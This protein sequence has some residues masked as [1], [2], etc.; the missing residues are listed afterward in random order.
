MSRIRGYT[1][2]AA[3]LAARGIGASEVA[4]IRGR[5]TFRTAW[6]VWVARQPDPPG[7]E[8]IQQT[9]RQAEGHELEPEILAAYNAAESRRTGIS[10]AARRMQHVVVGHAEFGW[11]TASPDAVH[12]TPETCWDR[13]ER[14]RN[15]QQL[16][17]I[18]I[19]DVAGGVEL[20]SDMHG[21]YWSREDRVVLDVY[22]PEADDTIAPAEYLDQV[23]WTLEVT[24]RPWWDLAAW[25][26]PRYG[27]F[28]PRLK[29]VRVM[30]DRTHQR[31]ILLDVALW[32]QRHLVDGIPLDVD[33]SEACRLWV[34]RRQ[35]A[36]RVT[37]R[38]SDAEADLV[39][40]LAAA[41]ALAASAEADA[42]RLENQ[43]LDSIGDAY[44]IRTPSHKA[45]HTSA[46]RIDLRINRGFT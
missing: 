18:D 31:R 15:G 27:E 44:A 11:A 33:D 26:A 40:Q 1:D 25:L 19:P 17:Q 5:S 37:R 13:L 8:R 4:A 6:S 12:L 41:R 46:G 36:D 10:V 45:R 24:G 23:Y 20:K 16:R 28:R 21:W 3:W 32:R 30:A 29:I 14:T 7:L 34:S 2:R 35:P 9:P 43:L 42:R 22:T 38:A 39:A